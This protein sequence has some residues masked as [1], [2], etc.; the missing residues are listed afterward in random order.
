MRVF[1]RKSHVLIVVSIAVAVAAYATAKFSAQDFSVYYTAGLSLLGGRTD[2][3][4]AE[5]ANGPVMNYRYPPGFI[6][7]FTPFVLLPATASKFLFALFTMLAVIYTAA[8]FW[9]VFTEIYSPAPR[10]IL[11]GATLLSFK[12][13][14]MSVKGLNIHLI[15]V[16]LMITAFLYAVRRRNALGG[17]LFGLAGS[18]KVFPF[19]SLPYFALRKKW[20]FLILSFVTL[21]VFFLLPSFYFGFQKNVELHIEWFELVITPSEFTELNGPPNQS[22]IGE[23]ERLLTDIKYEQRVGDAEYPE[24]NAVNLDPA[25]VRRAG[26]L[27]AVVIGAI[28]FF[29][30]IFARGSR[31]IFAEMDG[32]AFYEFAFVLSMMLVVGPRTN[33]IY[34]VTLFVPLT[35]LLYE[36]AARRSK[37]AMIAVFVIAVASVLVPL[38]P[39]A[40]MSRWAHVIGFDFLAGLASWVGLLIILLGARKRAAP[41]IAHLP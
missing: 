38:I 1:E 8:Y 41:A 15:V 34:F 29:V 3:Y 37:A 10:W 22:L 9:K 26:L 36:I 17:F 16:C 24:I 33:S 13:V 39:G 30:L 28:T 32:H 25:N 2:L 18:L 14:L 5:F 31:S 7:L 40:R 21:A 11:V 20:K 35:V 12:W 6:L 19:A 27:A 4:S 23:L